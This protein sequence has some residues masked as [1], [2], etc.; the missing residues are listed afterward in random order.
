MFSFTINNLQIT[1][2]DVLDVLLVGYIF[3]RIILL[4]KGTRAV[5][6]VY[7]LMVIVAAYFGAGYFGLYTLNW[8]LGNFLGSIF[9]VVIIL[10]R[11]DIRK[12]LAVMG[13]TT[14]FKKDLV[15]AGVLNELIL[16]LL[17]MAKTKTG[18]LIV[19][20]RNIPLSDVVS[21]GIELQANFSKDLLLTL[22]NT[23]TPLHDGAVI[24]RENRIAA[25]ACILPLAVGLKHESSLG[26]RH[27]AALGVTE[28]TDAVA[29]VVSEE[30]GSI[31]LAVGGRITSGLNEVRLQKVLTAA[32]RK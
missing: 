10:F 13:A 12:A 18:A 5:S 11:R 2:R 17:Q 30:R 21:G 20:E 25:A 6:V 31:S 24:I 15:Q 22:F 32:L 19:L 3:F 4:I 14:L 28:E 8:L 29:L 7:G 16:A 23:D 27:R 1:W 9:L 26:T